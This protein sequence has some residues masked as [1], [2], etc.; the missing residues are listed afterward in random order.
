MNMLRYLFQILQ[1]G[2]FEPPETVTDMI[3]A[4]REKRYGAYQ[5][6]KNYDW[7]LLTAMAI[8]LPLFYYGMMLSIWFQKPAP[9]LEEIH[10]PDCGPCCNGGILDPPPPIPKSETPALGGKVVRFNF[11]VPD[12]KPEPLP[13]PMDF[14]DG[15]TKQEAFV[16]FPVGIPGD[17]ALPELP[18]EEFYDVDDFCTCEK[19]ELEIFEELIQEQEPDMCGC[20]FWFIEEEPRPVNLKEIKDAI[21]YNGLSG[22]YGEILVNVQINKRGEYHQHEIL[23]S[24][25][26]VLQEAVEKEIADIKFTPAIQAGKPIYFWVKVPFRFRIKWSEKSK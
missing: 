1:N 11:P 14:V 24:D 4:N 18:A 17:F 21:E 6:R 8:V 13:P 19:S 26:P 10:I 12:P 22:R 5:L 15:P 25:D 23:R 2:F 9:I 16:K 7:H 3:F 20:G